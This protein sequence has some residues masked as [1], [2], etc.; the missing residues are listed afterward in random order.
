MIFKGTPSYN[1]HIYLTN[2]VDLLAQKDSSR[3]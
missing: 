2:Q 1:S 3:Y